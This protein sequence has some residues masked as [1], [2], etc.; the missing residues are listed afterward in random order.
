MVREHH[1]RYSRLQWPLL[2]TLFSIK[3]NGTIEIPFYAA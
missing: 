3:R 1:P 2:P